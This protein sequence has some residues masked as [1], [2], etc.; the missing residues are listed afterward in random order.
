MLNSVF[1]PA[2][3]SLLGTWCPRWFAPCLVLAALVLVAGCS[4][5]VENSVSGKVLLNGKPVAGTVVFIWPDKKELVSPI[6]PDGQY[7]FPNPT[8]GTVTI[9]VKGMG[10]GP[11][12]GKVAPP[13]GATGKLGAGLGQG[14]APP[15][16]YADARTSGLSYDIKGGKETYDLP[17]TP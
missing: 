9:L 15:A 13:P 3:R 8:R 2:R 11:T 7:A 16:R 4:G 1:P 10:G 6:G 17:L 12:G 5:K 14:E